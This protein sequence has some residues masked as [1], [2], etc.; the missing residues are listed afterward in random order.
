MTLFLHN[1]IFEYLLLHIDI[2]QY[3][4]L[5]NVSNEFNKVFNLRYL[6]HNKIYNK[7]IYIRGC[8]QYK[9]L[10]IMEKIIL[11]KYKLKKNKS[12]VRSILKY[13][14]LT[15]IDVTIRSGFPIVIEYLIELIYNTSCK[16][17]R[18]VLKVLNNIYSNSNTDIILNNNKDYSDISTFI[19]VCF[20]IFRDFDKYCNNTSI[21][22]KL[23]ISVYVFM[24]VKIMSNSLDIDSERN[25][26]NKCTTDNLFKLQNQ[27]LDEYIEF[28]NNPYYSK[29]FPKYYS[30]SIINII[31]NLYISIK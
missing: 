26:K 23:N 11:D 1:D 28:I 6:I 30:K 25:V 21:L 24:L 31:N 29:S 7:L 19:K 13:G 14:D 8:T 27:K 3:D 10:N 15:L 17:H 18:D 16:K 20:N 4:K 22:Y 2:C 9:I 5:K 12:I